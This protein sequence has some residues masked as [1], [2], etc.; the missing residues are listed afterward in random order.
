MDQ[1]VRDSI[2]IAGLSPLLLGDP[3]GK[4]LYRHAWGNNKITRKQSYCEK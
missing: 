3:C 2:E 4:L 1:M